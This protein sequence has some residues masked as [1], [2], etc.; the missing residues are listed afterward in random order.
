[1]RNPLISIIV[2]IYKV[3]KYLK[4]CVDSVL[5][6]TFTD[7]ELILVD[8]GSPDNCGKICDEYA[9]QDSRIKVIHK[10]NGG[11]VS[12]RQAGTELAVGD[13]IVCLDGDDYLSSIYCEKIASVVAKYSSDI[14]M[15]GAVY[16]AKDD[17]KYVYPQEK[18]GFYNNKDI[19][20]FFSY[21]IEDK[22]GK[23]FSPSIWNKVYKRKLYTE[24]QLCIDK[25]IKIGEDHCLT[26]PCL[27]K[28]NSLYV[29][30][31][32]LYYYRQNQFSMT[33]NKSVYDLYVPKL[34]AQ[35]FE[36]R[37]DM[38]ALDFQQQVY[39]RCV[40]DLF[41]A[42]VSQFNARDGYNEA[43]SKIKVALKDVYYNLAIKNAKF[44]F[45]S[46]GWLAQAALRHRLFF[47][48]F[49]FN[50]KSVVTK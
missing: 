22:K 12:A 34:I 35:H 16:T 1:M 6:Q 30:N 8:D 46:K 11:L 15:F 32:C 17:E 47:L 24:L 28:A 9:K 3:E 38:S 37:I 20:K 13:Y 18:E 50:K 36:Q 4:E 42:A 33:K 21:L 41:N 14:V 2:P 40:H 43:K 27:Y 49:L 10:L 23:Y 29:I 44:K 7:F 39:R 5:K 26:K 19:E 25:K 45:L 48:M 31:E